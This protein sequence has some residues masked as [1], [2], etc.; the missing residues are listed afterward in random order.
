[1]ADKVDQSGGIGECELPPDRGKDFSFVALSESFPDGQQRDPEYASAKL[2][3]RS[4]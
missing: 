3:S 2:K 1:V 4:G